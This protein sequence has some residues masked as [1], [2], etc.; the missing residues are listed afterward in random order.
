MELTKPKL[1]NFKK[2]LMIKKCPTWFFMIFFYN[3]EIFDLPR[4]SFKKAGVF[5]LPYRQKVNKP[6]RKKIE[7]FLKNDQVWNPNFQI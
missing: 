3:F 7:E 1:I 4:G 6:E 2:K 5:F